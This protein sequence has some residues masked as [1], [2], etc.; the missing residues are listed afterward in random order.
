MR[1]GKVGVE[2][3]GVTVGK[4]ASTDLGQ[5]VQRLGQAGV[6]GGRERRR[7]RRAAGMGCSEETN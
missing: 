1:L 4:M 7:A 2:L 6:D 5:Q 3:P